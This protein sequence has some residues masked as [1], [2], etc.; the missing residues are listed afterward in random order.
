[1]LDKSKTYKEVVELNVDQSSFVVL[2]DNAEL[3]FF[4]PFCKASLRKTR[5]LLLEGFVNRDFEVF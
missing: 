2:K 1:M 4:G 5:V 3:D